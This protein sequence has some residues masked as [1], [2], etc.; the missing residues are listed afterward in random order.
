MGDQL[1][2]T[3]AFEEVL[4]RGRS[5]LVE[6]RDKYQALEQ[7]ESVPSGLVEAISDLE[8]ELEELDQTLAVGETDLELAQQTV[9]RISVLKDVFSALRE[10][11][12]TVVEA[13][14]SRIEQYVSGIVALAR[15]HGLETG[16]EQDLDSIERQCS[17]LHALISKGRHEKVVTNDRVSPGDVSTSIRSVDAELAEHVPDDS[18][19]ETYTTIAE[20]LLDEIHDVLGSLGEENKDRTAY[21]SDLGS[22]KQQLKTTEEA[23]ECDDEASAAQTAR[24]ALEGTLMLNYATA[25]SLADQRVVEELADTVAES[26]FVVDCDVDQ[27]VRRGDANTL[28]MAITEAIGV[29]VELSTGERLRQLLDEHDGSVLRTA[30]VT[31]FDVPTILDHLERL[32][33]DGQVADLRVTFEQ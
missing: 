9:Q 2:P 23:R 3:D 10:R 32:Y 13:D 6:A 25:R 14:V 30:R 17:M 22:V 1:S 19:A 12:R 11:Q 8:Q 15:D 16:F 21:S 28:L 24:I 18:R 27:C 5:E 33:D 4:E 20:N 7:T 26:E 31:D 29:E